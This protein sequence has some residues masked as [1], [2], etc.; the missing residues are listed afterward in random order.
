MNEWLKKLFQ[1]IK[2]LWA[3][4][5]T[6]QKVILIGITAAVIAALVLVTVFITSDNSAAV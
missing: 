1:Q 3:K 6:V 4:W 5:S 2:E